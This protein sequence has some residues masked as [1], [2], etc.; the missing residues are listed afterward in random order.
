MNITHMPVSTSVKNPNCD[1]N[2]DYSTSASAFT[3]DVVMHKYSEELHDDPD[4]TPTAAHAA[5]D[6]WMTYA[7]CWSPASDW[8]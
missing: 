3:P 4:W 1:P 8:P 7:R 2:F 6:A 5:I